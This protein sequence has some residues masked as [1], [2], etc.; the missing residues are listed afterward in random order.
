MFIVNKMTRDVFSSAIQA[1]MQFAITQRICLRRL[2]VI[3]L[4]QTMRN[5]FTCILQ[6]IYIRCTCKYYV[7]IQINK[8]VSRQRRNILFLHVICKMK[9]FFEILLLNITMFYMK[10]IVAKIESNSKS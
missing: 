9:N 1:R 4:R 2:Q 3:R 10:L 8:I 6:C 5:V 7:R